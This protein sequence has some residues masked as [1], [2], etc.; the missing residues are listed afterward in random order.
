MFESKK[1]FWEVEVEGA[2]DESRQEQMEADASIEE[3][4]EN[5]KIIKKSVAQVGG[6][7]EKK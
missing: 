1:V 4:K 7:T 3:F 6:K 2:E 5:A